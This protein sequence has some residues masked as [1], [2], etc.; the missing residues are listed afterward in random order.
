MNA[1]RSDSGL[2]TSTTDVLSHFTT[3]GTIRAHER[4]RRDPR[5]TEVVPL[6]EAH[7]TRAVYEFDPS[8][9]ADVCVR[10]EHAL[11][12]VARSRAESLRQVVNWNPAFTFSFVLHHLVEHTGTA[13]TWGEFVK[14]FTQDPTGRRMLGDPIARKGAEL[15]VAG[16]PRATVDEALHW[17]VGNAY[18]SFLRELWFVTNLRE[19]GVDVRMHPLADALFRVDAWYARTAMIL[20]VKNG[21]YRAGLEGR[22]VHATDLLRGASPPFRLRAVELNPARVFGRVHLP[23]SR[24]IE[25]VGAQLRSGA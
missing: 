3:P 18:Y 5:Y 10:T 9:I 12:D 19:L 1:H 22:K 2:A 21:E 8:H 15:R 16:L 17:R 14:Y 11:G 24:D 20:Y 13:P 6:V 23:S 4:W 25:A 7:T